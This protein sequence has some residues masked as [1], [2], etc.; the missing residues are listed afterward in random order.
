MSTKINLSLTGPFSKSSKGT[1][2]HQPNTPP[3]SAN[4]ET[5]TNGFCATIEGGT[6]ILKLK[7]N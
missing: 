4:E 3:S 5:C 6:K 7:G 2:A 1:N